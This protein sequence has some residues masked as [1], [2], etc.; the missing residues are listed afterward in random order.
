MKFTLTAILLCLAPLVYSA[1]GPGGVD[2]GYC[3]G[4]CTPG[5]ERCGDGW[6]SWHEIWAKCWRCCTNAY[7]IRRYNIMYSDIVAITR[8]V[9]PLHLIAL[10]TPSF[11]LDGH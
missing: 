3:T 1:P 9:L 2:H 10:G 4:Y 7:S 8:V 6:Y 11:H 5:P